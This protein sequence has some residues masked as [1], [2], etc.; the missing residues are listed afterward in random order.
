MAKF[1][2]RVQEIEFINHPDGN[3]W[4]HFRILRFPRH[5]VG[6]ATR[7]DCYVSQI[8]R[9]FHT[10]CEVEFTVDDSGDLPRY[11]N[12]RAAEEGYR[13]GEG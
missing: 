9:A 1:R 7:R 2:S 11:G 5:L 4:L 6:M 12:F 10:R 13:K 3:L 8:V